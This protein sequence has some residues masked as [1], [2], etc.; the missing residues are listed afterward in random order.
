MVSMLSPNTYIIS[1]NVQKKSYQRNKLKQS[2]Q[3]IYNFRR[4]AKS[5]PL[6]I[7]ILGE[8]LCHDIIRKGV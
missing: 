6:Y 5:M 7:P 4:K 1:I 3:N 2:L 8:K